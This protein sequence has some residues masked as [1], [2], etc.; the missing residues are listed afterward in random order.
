MFVWNFLSV[1]MESICKFCASIEINR[2]LFEYETVEN[3]HS[4]SSKHLAFYHT[5]VYVCHPFD[6]QTPTRK[7]L[8]S[9][10]LKKKL[11]NFFLVNHENYKTWY[12][13]SVYRS[14]FSLHTTQQLISHIHLGSL[15]H[16]SSV[17]LN[18]IADTW[19]IVV[20]CYDSCWIHMWC[21]NSAIDRYRQ[22]YGHIRDIMF[23]L[24]VATTTA[25]TMSAT[26]S[27]GK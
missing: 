18:V 24:T 4:D 14:S 8:W 23:K 9:W 19:R 15:V 1:W 20:G 21:L 26:L 17:I 22:T 12:C 27:K 2:K 7:C 6:R 10:A 5:S 11:A 25:M 3:V 13:V 16:F